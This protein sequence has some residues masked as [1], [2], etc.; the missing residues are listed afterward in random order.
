[1]ILSFSWTT[2]VLLAGKKN[3]TRRR[4]SAR[5]ARDEESFPLVDSPQRR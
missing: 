1:M 5:T 3:C 2:D 4:W